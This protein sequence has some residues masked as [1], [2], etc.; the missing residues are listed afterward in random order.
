MFGAMDVVP[1]VNLRHVSEE[2]RGSVDGALAKLLD[3]TDH[4]M[5]AKWIQFPKALFVFLVVRG[6]PG[7][8]AFYIYDRRSKIWLWVDFE[9][10]NFGGY[11]VIDC[12]RLVRECRF[13]DLV[14]RPELLAGKERWIVQP[15]LRPQQIRQVPLGATDRPV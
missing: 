7:S 5:I 1:I 15:G 4:P 9:D 6:D 13:L 3:M 11:T 8:G 10:E 12:E 14:E 2:P